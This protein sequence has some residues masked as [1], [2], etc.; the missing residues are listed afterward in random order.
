M[1]GITFDELTA[2]VERDAQARQ[3]FYVPTDSLRITT[4]KGNSHLATP[5]GDFSLR[6]TAH[7]H[8]AELCGI[9]RRYYR[10]LRA[11]G[12]LLD[13]NVNYWLGAS[14]PKPR[15]IRA[16]DSSARA[17]VSDRYAALDNDGLLAAVSPLIDDIGGT[18]ESCQIDEGN[19]T[20]KVV[21][22]RLQ[23]EVQKNDVVQFGY[24]L[25]NSE[26]R[27]GALSVQPF[28][29]RLVCLNGLIAGTGGLKSTR[30]HSG[31]NWHRD[32]EE[33]G[34]VPENV[35]RKEWERSIWTQLQENVRAASNDAAF[36]TLLERLRA[37]T[38]LHTTLEPEQVVER[39]GSLGAEFRL[40]PELQ[41]QIVQHL[42]ADNYDGSLWN[43]VNG[44]TRTAQDVGSY[45]L[46]T[47]LEELGGRL[48]NLSPNSWE[49]LVNVN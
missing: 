1:Q 29:F 23:G 27:A 34:L 28:V 8:L 12:P 9:D 46:A 18:I 15:V 38:A 36:Q 39:L 31:R 43:V 42:H 6:D 25:K 10:R 11:H 40:G 16:L 26:V 35:E 44:V 2:Q 5:A 19:L 20:I 30:K 17:I 22:P 45:N 4:D 21:S 37:T 13:E 7:L 14:G 3:D 49:R 33:F 32:N 41:S 47:S 24:V 48:S